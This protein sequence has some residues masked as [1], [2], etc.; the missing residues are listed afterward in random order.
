MILL[1]CCQL[2]RQFLQKGEELWKEGACLERRQ[3]M[4]A[5]TRRREEPAT[6]SDGGK[7]DCGLSGSGGERSPEERGEVER[8]RGGD[9]GETAQLRRG[10]SIPTD[11]S[12][13][14]G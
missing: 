11:L 5:G 13:L 14:I 1:A 2:L 4:H 8:G 3:M 7:W 12:Q 6:T 9:Q 10:A